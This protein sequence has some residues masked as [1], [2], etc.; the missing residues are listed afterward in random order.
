MAQK[1]KTH[2]IRVTVP[3]EMQLKKQDLESLRSLI[4]AQVAGFRPKTKQSDEPPL[5]ETNITSVGKRR[6]KKSSK[7]SSTK[8]PPTR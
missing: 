1:A 6:R 2:A 3:E 5:Q 7:K 4:K 8:R